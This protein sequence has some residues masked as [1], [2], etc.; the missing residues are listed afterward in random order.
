MSTPLYHYGLQKESSADDV[1]AALAE[2]FNIRSEAETTLSRVYL[3]SFDWRL[4]QAGDRLYSKPFEHQLD[5]VW[6][7]E[8]AGGEVHTHLDRMPQFFTDLPQGAL[9]ERLSR[10]LDIRALMPQV[11]VK[12]RVRLYKLLDG[13]EKT[14][15]RLSIETLSSRNPEED[16]FHDLPERIRLQS[17]RG[18]GTV[19]KQVESFLVRNLGLDRLGDGLLE[20]ALGVLGRRPADYSSKL[21]FHF[22]P[23]A[24]AGSVA[25]EIHLNLLDTLERNLPG[26]CAN[27]DTEFLHDL[28]VAVRRTRSALT[29]IKGVFRDE[30]VEPFKSGLGW[31][32]QISGPSRDLDVYLLDYD[33]YRASLP[34]R[35]RADLDPL[36]HFLEEHR[37]SAYREMVS[38]LN[39]SDCKRLLEDW[40]HFLN[41]PHEGSEGGD[42]AD[43]PVGQVA[44]KRIYR[45]YKRVISE[46]AQINDESSATAFHELRRSCKKLRYLIEF[47]QSLYP[48]D[49][50]QP[51]IKALKMLLDN[52][53]A[54]QDTEVQ[55]NKLR[56]FAHQ[57][58]A[59]GEVPA[60]TLLAMG[61]LVDGLLR[62]QQQARDE[63]YSHFRVFAGKEN[64][65]ECKAL[66]SAAAS[67][68]SVDA[69]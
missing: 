30:E 28:R 14:V 19:L 26:T 46:G 59:E 6:I 7:G 42:A 67:S 57:M 21:D 47:F 2:Q 56:E 5:L 44:N 55:A 61:M 58:V 12:G 36:R 41:C 66:F 48:D 22:D 53:G 68:G 65:A 11:E 31:I 33:S 69:K 15:L 54:Y 43:K 18:Y 25:R 9:R 38:H 29:Q 8:G 64:K 16:V 17:V 37:Q 49:K 27:V 4:Y 20:E 63:F 35:F 32:G 45:T 60:D 10:L 23:N 24:P 51:L 34:E 40:R 13:E 62:R 50:I 39:S 1:I 3:D 52:L